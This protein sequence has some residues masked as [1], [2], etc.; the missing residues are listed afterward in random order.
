MTLT[1][2]RYLV[3]IL[4]ALG[5]Y[6]CALAFSAD[7]QRLA[8]VND[9]GKVSVWDVNSHAMMGSVRLVVEGK[10]GQFRGIAISRDGLTCA[11]AGVDRVWFLNLATGQVN[12]L[13]DP[14]YVNQAR[15]MEEVIGYALIIGTHQPAME[16]RYAPRPL[17]FSADDRYVAMVRPNS[18]AL[19]DDTPLFELRLVETKTLGVV[20]TLP[21]TRVFTFTPD[22][23]RLVLL[24]RVP[25]SKREVEAYAVGSW[26]RVEE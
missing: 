5:E 13:R 6:V 26:K 24:T 1:Q 3:A 15:V 20:A 22:G 2:F 25:G 16:L 9:E 21:G 14:E 8:A 23:R 10:K 19:H 18:G 7:G 17:R 12:E 11:V 4:E